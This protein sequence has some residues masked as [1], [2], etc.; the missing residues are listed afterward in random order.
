[1]FDTLRQVISDHIKYWPQLLG[2]ARSELKKTYSGSTLGWAWAF[3][4]P[5]VRICVYLFA[6]AVG[7]KQ[8]RN[9]GEFTYFYFLLS[10]IIVWFMVQ[11]TFNGGPTCIKRH[12][13]MVTKIK[14]PICLI[15]TFTSMAQLVVHLIIVA[16]TMV[17]FVLGGHYPTIYWLQLP[18]FTLLL[19]LFSCSWGLFAGCISTMSMD[20]QQFV[21]SFSMAIFWLSGTFFTFDNMRMIYQVILCLNP[22]A[23]IVKGYRDCFIYGRWFWETPWILEGIAVYIVLT[24]MALAVYKKLGKELP[25]VL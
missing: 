5:V 12:R 7:L 23:I 13:F 8:T 10:G 20:F 2:L 25:D 19:F 21:K 14:F 11:K 3:A 15:P 6:F 17:A 24:V 4:N 18:I 22:V 9:I 16:A 1:M